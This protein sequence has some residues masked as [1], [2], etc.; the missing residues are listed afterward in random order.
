MYIQKLVGGIKALSPSE[1][2][3]HI[4]VVSEVGLVAV[5]TV[6]VDHYQT[7][8]SAGRRQAAFVMSR[9][10]GQSSRFCYLVLGL[11]AALSLA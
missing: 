10:P 5:S 7:A 9:S 1:S 2:I 3:V 11:R 8:S 6:R 4:A